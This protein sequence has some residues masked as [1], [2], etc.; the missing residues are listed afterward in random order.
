MG[1]LIQDVV[2]NLAILQE[3]N[4]EVPE[5]LLGDPATARSVEDLEQA[6]RIHLE[7]GGQVKQGLDIVQQEAPDTEPIL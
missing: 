5:L 1:E 2:V 4:V 3:G 7:P 6:S